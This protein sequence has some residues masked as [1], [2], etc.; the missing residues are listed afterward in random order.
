[1][2]ADD[3]EGHRKL[4]ATVQR[5]I[6]TREPLA[7]DSAARAQAA[8]DRLTRVERGDAVGG[9]GPPLT[10]KDILRITGMTEAKLRH[11]E[12]VADIAEHG[13]FQLLQDEQT[14]RREKDHK[15]VVRELHRLLQVT[16]P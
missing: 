6:A 13:W 2:H 12:Q 9:I 15:A 5:D 7:A 4:L 11:C 10:R 8:K 14:R 3:I 16:R 1:M